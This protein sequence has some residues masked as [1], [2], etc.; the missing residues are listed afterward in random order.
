M[1]VRESTIECKDV[2][3]S[4]GC[5]RNH[6]GYTRAA[7]SSISSGRSNPLFSPGL[8]LRR[9]Y[10]GQCKGYIQLII[11]TRQR[12]DHVHEVIIVDSPP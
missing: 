8:S 7:Q 6:G 9:I 1:T 12:Q 4:L 10:N 5:P 2:L 3:R 11:Y